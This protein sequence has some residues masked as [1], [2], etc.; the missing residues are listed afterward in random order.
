MAME[1]NSGTADDKSAGF[2]HSLSQY[3]MLFSIIGYSRIL[4]PFAI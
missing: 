2:E 3:H 1:L 4:I